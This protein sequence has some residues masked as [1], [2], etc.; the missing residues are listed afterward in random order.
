MA[1][2]RSRR[3]EAA[4][5]NSH[6]FALAEA[7]RIHTALVLA[8][9]VQSQLLLAHRVPERLIWLVRDEG[10]TPSGRLRD[11]VLPI[12]S[13]NLTRMSQINLG[14]YSAT[15]RGYI[16]LDETVM[17]LSGIAGSGQLDLMLVTKPNRDFPW[18][19]NQDLDRTKGLVGP[20]E[21]G[22]LLELALRFAAQGREG[23]PIG[24]IFV[25]GAKEQLEPFLR[26]LILNPCK[27]HARR[28]RS[29][30]SP[31]FA[32]SLREF[33]ALDGAVVVNRDGVVESVGT[34]LDAPTKNVRLRRGL[35]ARHAAAAAITRVTDAIAFAISESSGTVT[36]FDNGRSVLEL[37][38]P[39]T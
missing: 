37:E 9:E 31:E 24:A 11:L 6:A 34:Y 12:P 10:E 17:C 13:A 14:L 22:R 23:K 7:L 18:L 30:H 25:L 27:G 3:E 29:I 33:C 4:A 38:R 36:L 2:V 39:A 20:K 5:F 19:R 15:L 32:E 21:F 26:Q 16:E 1:L 8:D 35:G 28:V